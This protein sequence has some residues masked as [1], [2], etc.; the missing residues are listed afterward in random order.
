MVSSTRSSG[1]P[2][3]SSRQPPPAGSAAPIGGGGFLPSNDFGDGQSSN[4]YSNQGLLSRSRAD[5]SHPP[6]RLSP[7]QI[8]RLRTHLDAVLL[9]INRRFA[10]RF[11]REGPYGSAEQTAAAKEPLSNG[12]PAASSPNAVQPPLDT[13]ERFAQAWREDVLPLVARIDVV[14]A[15]QTA[16]A[17]AYAMSI[18]DQIAQGA[19][20]YPQV[21]AGVEQQGNQGQAEEPAEDGDKAERKSARMVTP[22]G[23]H[24]LLVLLHLLD[25]LWTALLVGRRLDLRLAEQRAR[26]RLP[27]P[28]SPQSEGSP[29]SPPASLPL[30]K[31]ERRAQR[32]QQDSHALLG[33]LGA[34]TTSMT[35][36][37]RLRELLVARREDLRRWIVGSDIMGAAGP[38]DFGEEPA[39]RHASRRQAE[40]SAA[41]SGA[42]GMGTVFGRAAKGPDT[43]SHLKRHRD[44]QEAQT[45]EGAQS[46]RRRR[47]AGA[48][49]VDDDTAELIY[50]QGD[51]DTDLDVKDGIVESTDEPDDADEGQAEDDGEE[52]EEDLEAVEIGEPHPQAQ[53]ESPLSGAAASAPAPGTVPEPHEAEPKPEQEQEQD[54]DFDPEREPETDEQRHFRD[55]FDR[56][57]DPDEDDD[58]KDEDEDE[59]EDENE[60]EDE[61]GGADEE[62]RDQR[63]KGGVLTSDSDTE[64]ERISQD[65]VQLEAGSSPPPRGAPTPSRAPDGDAPPRPDR[66]QGNGSSRGA[67]AAQGADA[68]A[69]AGAEAEADADADLGVT[70]SRLFSRSLA[71]LE[72]LMASGSD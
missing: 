66:R 11:H 59:D 34:R 65:N 68:D 31:R 26:A 24:E 44:G 67:A 13:L 37:V 21:L 42:G 12:A 60:D 55:L 32:T 45:P 48:R 49:A 38:A 63:E 71:V 33:S 23:I 2:A 53:A 36:R 15:Q 61:G 69:D 47:A 4:D 52:E 28:P 8:T 64:R 35:D 5:E 41:A 10:K 25:A 17:V 14:G 70:T 58:S 56:K 57:I 7:A 3:S 51:L 20:G 9:S 54:G 29:S 1:A 19:M 72:R 27:P 40:A 30:S 62:D 39:R 43:S 50:E 18:T 6:L 46:K 22:R 16:T